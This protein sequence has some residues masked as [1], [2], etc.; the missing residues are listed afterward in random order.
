MAKANSKKAEKFGEFLRILNNLSMQLQFQVNKLV[1]L[2]IV[3]G[4]NF[5][6]RN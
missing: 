3:A 4:D 6:N 2:L 1:T 5:S